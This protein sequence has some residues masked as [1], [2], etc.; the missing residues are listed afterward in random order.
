MRKLF[1]YVIFRSAK[2]HTPAGIVVQGVDG[3][4]GHGLIWSH[5][6]GAWRYDPILSDEAVGGSDWETT[7][8]VSREEAERATPTAT[9]GQALPDEDTIWWIFQWKGDP[10]QNQD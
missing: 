8:L 7:D 5:R 6:A 1:Y 9:G 4:E 3:L 10:P 2:D